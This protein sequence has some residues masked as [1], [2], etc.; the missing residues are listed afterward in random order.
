MSGFPH[1]PGYR[2]DDP[3]LLLA[4]ALSKSLMVRAKPKL[5][6]ATPCAPCRR[7]A[8]GQTESSAPSKGRS[9]FGSESGRDE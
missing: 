6:H 1:G 7:R 5:S 8:C 9:C 3:D 2:E 4:I